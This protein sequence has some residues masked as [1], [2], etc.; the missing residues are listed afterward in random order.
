MATSPMNARTLIPII[1]CILTGFAGI[2]RAGEQRVEVAK[3]VSGAWLTPDS[4]W[5]GRTVLMLHGFADDMDG[6]GDLG[7]HLAQAMAAKGIASLRINFRG[8]GDRLRT[9]IESTFPTRLADTASAYAFLLKQKGVDVKHI[10][11]WGFS[12]GASTAIETGGSKPAWFRTMAVWS[13]PAGDQFAMWQQSAPEIVEKALRDGEATEDVPGWKK[14]TTKRAFYESFRG[15]DIDRSLAKYPGAF[16]TVR[17]S[18]DHL[19]QHDAE[20]LRIAPGQPAE[21]LLIGGADH[22]FRFFD[23]AATFAQRALDVTV[24]WFVRTL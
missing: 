3:G 5:D 19:P 18:Q 23:P 7:K 4:G 24:A 9:H 1:F 15:F 10:G 17:G 2:A 12:L 8:E 21:A 11:V 16:L 20:F 14:I 13:S 6:V 22:I